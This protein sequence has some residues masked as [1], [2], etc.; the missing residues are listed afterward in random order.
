MIIFHF[1]FMFKVEKDDI[2][3]DSFLVPFA[4]DLWLC[5]L[6]VGYD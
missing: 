2:V 5:L 3:T 1:L 4:T 6:L